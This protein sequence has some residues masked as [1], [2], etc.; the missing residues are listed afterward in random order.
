MAEENPQL[1]HEIQHLNRHTE[2]MYQLFAE[3][4][5]EL[6]EASSL[7]ASASFSALMQQAAN[8][9]RGS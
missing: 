9:F 2:R 3:T 6:K 1:Y 8:Y 7:E 5:Q 4:L